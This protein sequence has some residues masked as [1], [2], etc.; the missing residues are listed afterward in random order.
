MFSLQIAKLEKGH[1]SL[2]I[3]LFL[4]IIY[5]GDLLPNKTAKYQSPN[6]ILS[7]LLC[8]QCNGWQLMFEE[9]KSNISAEI[10]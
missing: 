8:K 5:S 6:K 2:K 3:N 4:F 10:F 7:E 1:N 9:S